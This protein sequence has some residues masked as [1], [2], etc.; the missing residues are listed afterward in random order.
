MLVKLMLQSCDTHMRQGHVTKI[1][2]VFS[3]CFW[4]Y[5]KLNLEFRVVTRGE[6]WNFRK[7][8]NFLKIPFFGILMLEYLSKEI[9][10]KCLMYQP[11]PDISITNEQI[12]NI[13]NGCYLMVFYRITW[14]RCVTWLDSVVWHLVNKK[15][16]IHCG[17]F[18]LITN[19]LYLIPFVKNLELLKS[20]LITRFP[21]R[22]FNFRQA[23]LLFW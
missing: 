14:H 11:C 13:K 15:I 2:W 1:I 23:D 17:C 4:S 7:F 12:A 19:V 18:K 16:L 5:D 10:Y 3:T 8:S 9:I 6:N 21:R 22:M 20:F